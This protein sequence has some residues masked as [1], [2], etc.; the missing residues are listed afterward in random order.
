MKN[1]NGSAQDRFKGIKRDYTEKD[2]E[3][4]RGSF[5]IEHTVS[6]KLSK[7]LWDYLNSEN[8]VNTLGSLSGNHAI[9]HAKAGL[10]AIYLSGWQVNTIPDWA[11]LNQTS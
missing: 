11:S 1:G 8:Y 7:K 10:R 5:N 2:V 9:Q 6:K 3:R 4:L